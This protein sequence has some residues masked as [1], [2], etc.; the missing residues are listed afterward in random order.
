MP[1]K[2]TFFLVPVS[3]IASHLDV[4]VEAPRLEAEGA[5]ANKVSGFRPVGETVSDL[6]MLE[7]HVPRDGVPSVV[8]GDLGQKRNRRV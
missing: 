2:P 6:A 8:L 4:V 3:G 1:F 5:V 7:N